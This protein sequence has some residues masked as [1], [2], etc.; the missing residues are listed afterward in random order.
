MF[1][2]DVVQSICD[3]RVGRI[4]VVDLDYLSWPLWQDQ[5]INLPEIKKLLNNVMYATVC[6]HGFRST[7]HNMGNNVKRR[8]RE[9]KGS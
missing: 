7:I 3:L 2:K 8:H 1:W 9:N 6:M 5:V 4:P